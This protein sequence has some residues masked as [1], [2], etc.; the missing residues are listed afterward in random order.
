MKYVETQFNLT[1]T[2]EC[3]K[4]LDYLRKEYPHIKHGIAVTVAKRA[5]R[6]PSILPSSLDIAS[7]STKQS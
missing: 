5:G 3:Q 7:R 2:A 6:L 4:D 1:T